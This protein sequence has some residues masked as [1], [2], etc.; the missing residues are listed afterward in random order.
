MLFQENR[1][2][3]GY[4]CRSDSSLCQA[5][6]LAKLAGGLPEGEQAF[7]PLVPDFQSYRFQAG[8]Q[9]EGIGKLQLGCRVQSGLQ[10]V[11]GDPRPEV[12]DMM[13]PDVA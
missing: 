7:L 1:L 10:V 3:R 9:E 6:P 11:I 2:Y 12:M 8:P 4:S 13:K 5:W